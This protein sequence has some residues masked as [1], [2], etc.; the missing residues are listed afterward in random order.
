MNKYQSLA[1]RKRSSRWKKIWDDIADSSDAQEMVI[2]PELE[3]ELERRYQLL[4]EGKTGFH[5]W[6]DIE[7]SLLSGYTI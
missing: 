6:E 4:K 5:S 7:K 2:S 1:W 3:A